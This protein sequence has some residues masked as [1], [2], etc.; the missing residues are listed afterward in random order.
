[1][2]TLTKGYTFGATEQVTNAKLHSLVDSATVT[3]IVNADIDSAASIATSKLA[4]ID[5]SKLTGL[6]NIVAGAGKI[7]SANLTV[8][9]SGAYPVGSV[10]ISTVATNP[11]STL[12][13][14][15]WS[16]LGEGR[17]LLGA[18]GGYT[19]GTTG[20]EA[21]HTLTEAEMPSHSHTMT[22]YG[23]GVA[24]AGATWGYGGSTNTATI[25]STGSGTAHNNLQPYLVVYMW[26]RT[27]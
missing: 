20:G 21:T 8:D 24:G 22:V 15:T 3:A 4:D 13:F 19:A 17:V 18:G 1:L 25:N 7:P 5:G 10:H 9:I 27:A 16:A 23:S 26:E 6:A 14:G 11:S 12:G 2:A